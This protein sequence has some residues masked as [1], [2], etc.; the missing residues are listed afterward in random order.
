VTSQPPLIESI[1]SA[2]ASDIELKTMAEKFQ[3]EIESIKGV[4]DVTLAGVKDQ[5]VIVQVDKTKLDQFGVGI[6]DI[7]NSINAANFSFPVGT[8]ETDE[9][10]YSV[11]LDAEITSAEEVQNIPIKSVDGFPIYVRDIADVRLGFAETQTLS[12][13]SQDGAPSENAITITVKKKTGGNIIGI[14]DA[15]KEKVEELRTNEYPEATAIVTFDLAKEVEKSLGELSGNGVGT[16][17]LITIL[18]LLFLGTRDA[19]LAGFSIPMTFLIGFIGL[20]AM[21]ST[22]NFLSLFSLI[23]ALGIVVDNGIVIAE[24]LHE[25]LGKGYSPKE[26][27]Q[28]TIKEFY[29]PL[30]SGTLTTVAAF[31]PMM[32][33]SGIMGQ[34]V[35][36]IPITVNLVLIGSLFTAL[37][38]MPLLG[39][40]F[41]KAKSE[42]KELQIKTKYINPR[43]EQLHEWYEKSIKAFLLDRK[44]KKKFSIGL[45]VAFI[46]SL[47]LPITGILAVIMF[48]AADADFF[49]ID[50]SA[51]LGT[52]F[53]VTDRVVRQVEES[54][55]SDERIESFFVNIGT[56][57]AERDEVSVGSTPHIASVTVNLEED[58]K[59]TTPQIIDEY[60]EK[61]SFITE[62]DIEVTQLESGPPTGAPVVVTFFGPEIVELEGLAAEAETLLDE[63]D[64]VEEITN[65]VR[66]ASLEFEVS[67]KREQIASKGFSPIQVAQSLRAAVQG[68]DASSLRIDGEDVDVTIKQS[69]NPTALTVEDRIVTTIDEIEQMVLTNPSGEQVNISSLVD[70]SVQP[71]STS[72]RHTDGDRRTFVNAQVSGITPGEVFKQ[73]EPKME[74]LAIPAGYTY[75]LGG[76]A[77]D[78]AESFRDLFRALFLGLFLIASILLLQFNSY[79]QPLFILVTLPLALI[80]V[81]PGLTLVGQPFSFPA[82]IGIVALSGVVVNDA[83]I[84]IDKINSRRKEGLSKFDA[85]VSGAKSRLQPILLTTITTIAGILPLTL[86]DPTWG[87]LGF[88][89]IFGLLFATVLTLVVVPMLYL[90]YAEKELPM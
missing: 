20:L 50:V 36:H 40:R 52:S 15:A 4:S 25:N 69:L 22:I 57:N 2:D 6:T 38:I 3:D 9:I 86:S 39:S 87:P 13:V 29:K 59:V 75:K 37:A 32:F 70:I 21:G 41:L 44:A 83:I 28:R 17:I 54:L 89:I 51:P 84:L 48:P 79:R 90:K 1:S 31:V 49:Y 88:S 47:A 61:L 42:S 11:R 23:L 67:L 30:I 80:G 74:Q 7:V 56:G 64:G 8:I 33:M 26:S 27:A 68:T 58:R 77:E 73:L 65:S 16:V 78:V 46:G 53:D 14:V 24:G 12:R 43:I 60:R 71:G 66:D 85:V 55:Y 5:E 45:V 34:F 62:A 18:L 81:L 10:R 76:E 72:I 35:R 63:I 19:L 82:F